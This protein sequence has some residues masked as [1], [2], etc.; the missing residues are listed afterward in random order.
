MVKFRRGLIDANGNMRTLSKDQEKELADAAAAGLLMQ[1]SKAKRKIRNR[2]KRPKST[3]TIL[4]E[5][6]LS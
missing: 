2:L 5:R 3:V 6:L 4:A 1:A